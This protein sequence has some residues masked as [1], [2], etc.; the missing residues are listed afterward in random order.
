MIRTC[1]MCNDWTK[2]CNCNQKSVW[3]WLARK[4]MWLQMCILAL[5]YLALS[6]MV[7]VALFSKAN[8]QTF[9]ADPT[10]GISP[11]KVTLVW[12]IPGLPTT[13]T[14]CKASG[15]WSGDK[16]AKGTLTTAINAPASYTLTCS[17][18]AQLGSSTLSWKPP[19]ANTD[20]STLTDLRGYIVLYGKTSTTL[21]TA[22]SFD[23]SVVP[24]DSATGRVTYVVK[25][26][27]AGLWYFAAQA[28]NSIGLQSERTMVVSKNVV[29]T[30]G[31]QT[32]AATVSVSVST[33]PNPPADITI[34]FTPELQP[35]PQPT[36]VAVFRMNIGGPAYTDKAGDVW[37]ADTCKNGETFTVRGVDIK[38]TD[39]DPLYLDY[40]YDFDGGGEI[41]CTFT[42]PAP[43]VCVID[44]LTSE[45]YFVGTRAGA[46]KR[47]F[48]VYV[49]GAPQIT[50]I[51]IYG[52]VGEHTPLVKTARVAVTDPTLVVEYRHRFEN[53]T[54]AALRVSCGGG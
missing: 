41:T 49:N 53:P 4:P 26:L 20:G 15:S 40:R 46:G 22:L 31:E 37:L 28:V 45:E 43:S 17:K 13:G 21:D 27:P 5:G 51:D 2:Y 42:V 24:I 11:V 6:A 25:N 34:S 7:I 10:N 52:E 39:D 14:P 23:T 12:D 8:A 9:T 48:D 38:G 44:T 33:Q 18:P 3:F 47:T 29:D 1:E 54:V 16:P 19:T 32:F 30:P 36:K 35:S 50:A